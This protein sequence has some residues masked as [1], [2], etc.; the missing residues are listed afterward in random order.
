MLEQPLNLRHWMISGK[1]PNNTFF[2]VDE[3]QKL[4]KFQHRVCRRSRVYLFRL[5]D[6]YSLVL[7]F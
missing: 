1:Q 4:N 2:L 3:F 7:P 5:C 6:L